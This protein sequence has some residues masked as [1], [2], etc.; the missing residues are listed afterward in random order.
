M[1]LNLKDGIKIYLKLNFYLVFFYFVNL[2]NTSS[3]PNT[4]IISYKASSRS[5]QSPPG[6]SQ[7][8][9]SQSC[10]E[11]SVKMHSLT[12][13]FC[14]PDRSHH[15]PFLPHRPHPDS[16]PAASDAHKGSWWNRTRC[17]CSWISLMKSLPVPLPCR[18][19]WHGHRWYRYPSYHG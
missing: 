6:G 15:A 16:S 5:L 18:W 1:K 19:K 12:L 17:D 9:W 7:Y 11:G 10:P 8:P 14:P 4:F 3:F 2:L 13:P